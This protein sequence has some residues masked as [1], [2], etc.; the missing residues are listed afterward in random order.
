MS[1]AAGHDADR[2]FADSDHDL[3]RDTPR[4]WYDALEDPDW[5]LNGRADA[6]TLVRDALSAREEVVDALPPSMGELHVPLSELDDAR[7]L[8]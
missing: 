5:A 3:L 6:L 7:D 8:R 2:V 4:R 1:Y